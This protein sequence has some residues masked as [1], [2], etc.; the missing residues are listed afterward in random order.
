[1]SPEDYEISEDEGFIL[2]RK[3]NAA[4]SLLANCD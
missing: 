4:E 1:M 2:I 3:N